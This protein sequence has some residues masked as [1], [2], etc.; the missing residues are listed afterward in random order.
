LRNEVTVASVQVKDDKITNFKKSKW[1]K[2]LQKVSLLSKAKSFHI[3]KKLITA[4]SI[5]SK[6]A[7]CWKK[8]KKVSIYSER[9]RKGHRPDVRLLFHI[10]VGLTAPR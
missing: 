7:N 2:K 9:K 4:V 3:L 6:L 1:R 5:R 10:M 8:M